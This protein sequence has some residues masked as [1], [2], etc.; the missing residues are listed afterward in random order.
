M[1]EKLKFS[2]NVFI[3][4]HVTNVRESRTANLLVMALSSE[5]KNE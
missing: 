3:Q 1:K 2:T 4:F 5:R